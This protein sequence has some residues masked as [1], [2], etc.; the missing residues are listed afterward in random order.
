MAQ[1]TA[2]YIVRQILAPSVNGLLLNAVALTIKNITSGAGAKV[3]GVAEIGGQPLFTGTNGASGS[4]WGIQRLTATPAAGTVLVPFSCHPGAADPATQVEV[5]FSDTGAITGVTPGAV[6]AYHVGIAS[7]IGTAPLPLY[8]QSDV[9]NPLITIG[10]GDCLV[11][12]TV[13]PIVAGSRVTL[14][15]R[16]FMG[17]G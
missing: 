8:V 3:I 11:V 4:L 16:W 9:D 15:I 13:T 2:Q 12:S 17:N 5:R 6:S 10:P 14:G 7:Q 1:N